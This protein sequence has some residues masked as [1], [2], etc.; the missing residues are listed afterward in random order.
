MYEQ[1]GEAFAKAIVGNVHI[2]IER[3]GEL[4]RAEQD[5]ERLKDFILQKLTE[6]YGSI[7]SSE[8]ETIAKMIGLLPEIAKEGEGAENG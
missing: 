6:P 4:L 8:I 1:L 3:Y 5:A 2:S 7:S